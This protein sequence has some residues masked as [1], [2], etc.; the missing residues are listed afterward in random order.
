MLKISPKWQKNVLLL[1]FLC[2]NKNSKSTAF[3][4]QRNFLNDGD[5]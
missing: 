1:Y 5:I 3:S 4:S 2:S